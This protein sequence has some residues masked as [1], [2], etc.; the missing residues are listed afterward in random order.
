MTYGLFVS[1]FCSISSVILGIYVFRKTEIG[2]RKI[3]IY[4]LILTCSLSAWVLGSGFRN[5]LPENFLR[6]APNWIL[7][8]TVLVPITLHE[9]VCFLTKEN[10]NPS[11]VRR[12]FEIILLAF[13]FHSG[14]QSNLIA[15][16]E[17]SVSIYKPM[18]AYHVLIAYSILYVGRSI[19]LLIKK[20]KK[21]NGMLRLQ[22]FIL[23]LG[24]ASAL[25]VAILF[26]YILPLFGIF[27]GYLSAFGVLSWVFCWTVAI[28]H[29][30][31]F[32][33]REKILEG[34]DTPI[35]S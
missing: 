15:V 2:Q 11:R 4:F 28:L 13:L 33:I 12:L 32:E 30:D 35:I 29:Y 31:A 14:I 7:L 27:K 20:S 19:F 5:L 3:R 1:I 8:S 21:S 25:F 10:F 16:S 23:M 18:P 24:V 17:T 6:T 26:V 9:L 22:A 34:K